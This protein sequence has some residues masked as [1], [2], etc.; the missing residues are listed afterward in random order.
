MA[1]PA[2]HVELQPYPFA[3]ASLVPHA[4]SGVQAV[5]QAPQLLLSLLKFAQ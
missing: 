4:V 5:W 2:G 3:P 1:C